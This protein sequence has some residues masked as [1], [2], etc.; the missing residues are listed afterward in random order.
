MTKK[1]YITPQVAEVV[2]AFHQQLLTGSIT[3]NSIIEEAAGTDV[4]GLAPG[5]TD[6][7]NLVNP[8]GQLGVPGM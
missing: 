2:V 6:F 4:E 7:D 5:F 8:L 3:G 1:K